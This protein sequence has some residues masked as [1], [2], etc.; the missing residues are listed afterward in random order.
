MNNKNKKIKVCIL[1]YGAGNIS[2]VNNALKFLGYN[3][4]ISN[5]IENIK[6]ATHLILPGVGAFDT[7]MKKINDNLPISFL[8]DELIMS[9]KPFLGI[10]VGMQVLAKFGYEF[11]KTNGLNIINGEVIKIKTTTLMAL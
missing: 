3:T 4:I 10:C 1:S 5:K 8:K 6:K 7:S 9:N 2:S 11:N